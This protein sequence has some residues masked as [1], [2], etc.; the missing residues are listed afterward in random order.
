MPEPYWG[1]PLEKCSI[2]LLDYNPAGGARINRHTTINCKECNGFCGED[3]KMT[4]IRYVNEKKKY[5]DLALR[6]PVLKEYDDLKWFSD[7]DNGYEGYNW[8]QEKHKWLNHLVNTICGLNADELLPFGIELC[9]WHSKKWSNNM[10]WIEDCKIKDCI[11]K[12]AIQPLFAAMKNSL[13]DVKIAVC[14]GAEFKPKLLRKFFDSDTFK[15][16]T[17]EIFKDDTKEIKLSEQD[18]GKKENPYETYKDLYYI[19]KNE[20]ENIHVIAKWTETKK[21]GKT[22]YKET[23]R[24]YRI[25]KITED[26]NNEKKNYYILNTHYSGS[27]SH[28]GE[29]FWPFE[30]VL[31]G[32]IKDYDLLD[33]IGRTPL[34][35]YEEELELLKAVQEKGTDS[36]EMRKLEKANMRFVVSVAN[37]YQ[38]QGLT[39]EELI[40]AGTEGL[41]K[42]AIKYN[43]EADFK[44]IAYAVWWI[45][46][47]IIQTIE[48]KKK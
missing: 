38:K 41:R 36:E 1:N 8:W 45:R 22:D 44:F 21:N 15:D 29:H 39:L 32:K 17:K 47:S 43:L 7:K 16:V 4:V 42:G 14:I 5:S 10:K 25:Y 27:N 48:S 20:E 26:I 2:V 13:G 35:T 24:N 11:K 3:N 18:L 33:E 46:Q 28:P 19:L 9:G 23:N 12:R 31:I 30:D 34:L 37:Q 6:C 40:E